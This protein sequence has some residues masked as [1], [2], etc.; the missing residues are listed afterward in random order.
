MKRTRLQRAYENM[1]QRCEYVGYN[2]YHRYGGR[3]IKKLFK[4]CKEFCEW[5]LA[6]GYE[7][8]LSLDRIDN[9]GHYEPSNCRWVT[10][11]ENDCNKSTTSKH[12]NNISERSNGTY[13]V[14]VRVGGKKVNVGTFR[15]VALAVAARDTFKQEN[16]L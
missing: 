15:T 3:G 7:E 6:N 8:H 12:G 2:Q 1:R 5:A 11:R 16:N 13:Q 14:Q 4:N 10:H 9:D